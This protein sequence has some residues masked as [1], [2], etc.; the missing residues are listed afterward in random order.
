MR[1]FTSSLTSFLI[2][3]TALASSAH[4][5]LQLAAFGGMNWSLDSTVKTDK[6]AVHDSRNVSWEGKPFD[7][8]PYWGARATYWLE[9][10][11]SWGV[12]V[13]YTHQKSYADIN[14]ATDLVYD[15]PEYTD[16]NNIVT[17]NTA[18]RWQQPNSH[19]GYYIGGGPG[20]A[21]PSVEVM[22]SMRSPP[23]RCMNTRLLGIAAEALCGA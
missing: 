2:A 19:W 10:N 15:H 11:S 23:N 7:L 8:P 13:D 22:L 17:L 4:A 5:E 6:G 3:A 9:K 20:V 18:Y 16:G 21:F 1:H 12:A 14:F